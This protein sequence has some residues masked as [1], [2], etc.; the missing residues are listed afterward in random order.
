MKRSTPMK[1]SAFKPKLYVPRPARQTDDEGVGEF[2][3][4]RA[5]VTSRAVVSRAVVMAANIAA[6]APRTVAKEETFRSEA[7]LRAV[8]S[9][10]CVFCGAPVQAAHRNE[11]K[12]MG[13]KV[14]DCLAAA[15]CPPEHAEIDQGKNMTRDERRARM[16]R[17]IV[18]TLR[19]LVR[20]G[21]VRT[22]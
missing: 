2:T 3:L 17:A 14:D 5:A 13:L 21:L 18:L 6:E 10:P 4:Q 1:R 19:E 22:V 12:G 16:D 11:G 15:L 7:W 9:I 20:R 8:R